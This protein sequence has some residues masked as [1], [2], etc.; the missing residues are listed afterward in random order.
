MQLNG[1]SRFLWEIPEDLRTADD[2]RRKEEHG[3]RRGPYR[4]YRSW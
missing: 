1:F 3:F 2:R 4:G